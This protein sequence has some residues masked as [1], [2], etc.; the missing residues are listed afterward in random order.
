M[1]DFAA[2]S[3]T[4]LAHLSSK[5]RAFALDQARNANRNVVSLPSVRFVL[6]PR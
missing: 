5:D 2:L 4:A 1:V 3:P 6:R